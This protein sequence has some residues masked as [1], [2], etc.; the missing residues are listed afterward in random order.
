MATYYGPDTS[1][2]DGLYHLI[3]CSFDG[4]YHFDDH[5]YSMRKILLSYQVLQFY[6]LEKWCLEKLNSLYKAEI[7]TRHIVKKLI[8]DSPGG[9]VVKTA[10]PV[11][12]AWVQ[13]L[14]WE[15]R[16]HMPHGQKTEATL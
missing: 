6:R 12:G 4:L 9:P 3:T 11:Q 2:F 1:L 8:K 14:V 7:Q 13:S 10:L 15:L 16:F 5:N